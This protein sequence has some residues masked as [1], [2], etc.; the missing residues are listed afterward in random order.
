MYA[1]GRARLA[2]HPAIMC[3]LH[4][5]SDSGVRTRRVAAHELA[6]LRVSAEADT[7][8]ESAGRRWTPVRTLCA[9][10]AA[11]DGGGS[12]VED[13]MIMSW[14]TVGTMLM[15]DTSGPPTRGL[16]AAVRNAVQDVYDASHDMMRQLDLR[17]DQ[18]DK[19]ILRL[20]RVGMCGNPVVFKKAVRRAILRGGDVSVLV[21]ADSDRTSASA[22]AAGT[23]R[24]AAYQYYAADRPAPV[25]AGQTH[26]A[27]FRY[28]TKTQ[29]F[30]MLSPPGQQYTMRVNRLLSQIENAPDEIGVSL[31]QS[32]RDVYAQVSSDDGALSR[33]LQPHYAETKRPSV[34]AAE[35]SAGDRLLANEIITRISRARG[36][37]TSEGDGEVIDAVADA[38]STMADAS[39]TPPTPQA[40]RITDATAAA[41]GESA[42]V[43][44][45]TTQHPLADGGDVSHG[46]RSRV[47]ILDT[48]RI[49]YM[50]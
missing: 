1:T 18:A 43:P 39:K 9:S 19:W 27:V 13:Q 40:T 24:P 37:T 7:W 45:P 29:T 38:A 33:L 35:I 26:P 5:A 16:A 20:M 50:P 42:K 41:S 30:R 12:A 36:M 44:Q 25:M 3:H 32:V 2:R 46:E 48:A 11:V 49:R 31:C 21:V 17:P 15:L 10:A 6:S 28:D 22:S 14:R 34:T 8:F 4:F 23:G 47:S